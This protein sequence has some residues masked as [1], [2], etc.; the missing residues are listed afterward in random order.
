[1][2]LKDMGRLEEA[3]GRLEEAVQV[4]RKSGRQTLEGHSLAALGDVLSK[5]GDSDRALEHYEVSLE[6]RR[7]AGDLKG[8]GW[9]L[10]SIARERLGRGEAD[11]AR[12]ACSRAAERA[13]ACDDSELERVTGEL[14]SKMA[15]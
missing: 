14:L 5:K 1:V 6:I 15:G 9:M 2:T 10:W 13:R 11:S 4:N 7:A 12:D 8:E 3:R